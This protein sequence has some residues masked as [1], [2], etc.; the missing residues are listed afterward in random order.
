MQPQVAGSRGSDSGLL[1]SDGD[2]PPVGYVRG[3]YSTFGFRLAPNEAT[4]DGRE[5]SG[6][7]VELPVVGELVGQL[8]EPFGTTAARRDGVT[9]HSRDVGEVNTFC[10]QCVRCPA[11]AVPS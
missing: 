2:D 3:A 11:V 9:E 4:F 5:K 6:R 10:D 7:R 8:R 1:G